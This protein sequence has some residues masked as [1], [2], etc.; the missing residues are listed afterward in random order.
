MG[1]YQAV[2]QFGPSAANEIADLNT[3]LGITGDEL[4]SVATGV[5]KAKG[6][7]GE[8]DTNQYGAA[9]RSFNRDASESNAILDHMGTVA[10]ATGAPIGS[11]VNELQTYG[12]VLSNLGLSLEDTVS[13]FGKLNEAGVDT[14]RIMPGINASMRKAAAEGVTDLRR[15]LNGAIESI[16]AANTDTEA[17][18][19]ATATFGAEGAQRMTAAIRSGILP[20]LDE[21]NTAFGESAGKTTEVFKAQRSFR[22]VL[23]ET[24][25]KVM[26]FVGPAGDYVGVV[27]SMATT[28]FGFLTA[29]PAAAAPVAVA[30][31][32]VWAA[33]G[34]PVGLVI[35][36][37]VAL[38]AAFYTFRR[39][40][41]D[42]LSSVINFVRPWFVKFLGIYVSAAEVM[43]RLF[44]TN[45][46]ASVQ[47]AIDKLDGM[48]EGA[49]DWADSMGEA[50]DVVSTETVPAVES[51]SESLAGGPTGGA[52]GA[53]VTATTETRNFL[54]TVKE[55]PTYAGQAINSIGRLGAVGGDFIR[56]QGGA[57]GSNFGNAF[58]S[59]FLSGPGGLVTVLPEGMVN[60]IAAT[61]DQTRPTWAEFGKQVATSFAES[62]TARLVRTFEAGG[63]FMGAL[64]AQLAEMGQNLQGFLGQKLSGV[65][66]MV[67]LIGPLLAQF[68]P[69]L[70]AGIGNLAGK[71]WGAISGVF[72]PSAEQTA[73]RESF[74]SLHTFIKEELS[75]LATYTAEVQSA[76]AQGWDRTLAETVAG[77]LAAG[78]AAGVSRDEAFRLYEQ[79]QQAVRD[80]NT[81]V[82]AEIEQTLQA[83]VASTK[84]SVVELDAVVVHS[85]KDIGDQFRGL[86]VDEAAALGKA[87]IGLGHQA[88]RAFTRIHDSA[89]GAGSALANKLLPALH[90]VARAINAIPT[91]V[92]INYHGTFSGQHAEGRAHGGP[93]NAFSP[94]IVGERGPELFV[95]TQ[96]GTIIPN[97]GGGGG[98]G[99]DIVIHLRSEMDRHVVSKEMIRVHEETLDRAGY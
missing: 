23:D 14:S 67:P 72:G 47:K 71:V 63:S 51:Y 39:Q 35:A 57:L 17:L 98:R 27:G 8:F 21:L 61:T 80:G 85:A 33:L 93:V 18:T 97:G 43:D 52:A 84:D 24:K 88:N 37:I 28:V 15:H 6:A 11:L 94:Y 73:A 54:D 53:A 82:I 34:G 62:F 36:G 90:S 12:P 40:I 89:L 92:H 46:T 20:S 13:F 75:G 64:K 81:T 38:G 86:T 74:A 58:N 4:E 16:R 68:G 32:A 65:L 31:R 60:T 66:N 48:A 69:A 87:L 79:Y 41:G 77:F 26:A 70:I 55:I 22:D 99:R 7:F 25:N 30:A 1:S 9:L 45:L 78:E 59:G 83:W 96:P 44:G 49:A 91:D 5:L 29:F 2:S 10:Q 76:I 42:A 56:E 19:L 50:A 95:P 3:R